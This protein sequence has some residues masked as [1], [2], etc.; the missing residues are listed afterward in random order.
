MHSERRSRCDLEAK[1]G[2]MW[3]QVK[4]CWQPPEA[5]GGKEETLPLSLRRDD[6]PA[7]TLMSAPW[8]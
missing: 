3:P 1:I 4:K 7:S 5:T 8:K 2:V 6:S